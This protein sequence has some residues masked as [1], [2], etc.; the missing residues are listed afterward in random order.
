MDYLDLSPPAS[1]LIESIR[2]IGYSFEAAVADI[3]DN[4]ISAKAKNIAIQVSLN[5]KKQVVTSILDDGKGMTPNELKIAMSLG[6]KGPNTERDKSDLG[7]FG[8]GL[9]TASFSQAKLLRV[10]SK[11]NEDLSLYG[12]EWDLDHVI[13]TN[14]WQAREISSIEAEKKLNQINLEKFKNGTVVVWENCDRLIQG[15]ENYD[16]LSHHVNR[17]IF[18][19]NQ[20]LSLIFHKYLT[21][22]KLT[23]KINENAVLPMD[24]FCLLGKEDVAHSQELFQESLRIE[25]SKIKINGYLLPHINRMGGGARE[26]QISFEGDHTA[27]QGLYLYRLD[28]LIAYGGWQGIVR[29]SEANKL[30]RVE[31]SFDNEADNLWQ[32]DI[33]KATAILPVQIRSRIRDLVR[34]ASTKSKEV[35][36]SKTRMKKTNPNSIWE[37]VYDKEKKLI[38][39]QID[40]KHPIIQNF[41]EV[42]DSKEYLIDEFLFFI[43]NT[44]PADLISNDVVSNENKFHH[45]TDQIESKVEHLA[46]I[47]SSSGLEFKVFEQTILNCGLFGANL[48]DLKILVNKYKD[49][50]K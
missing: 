20:K 22:K 38:S 33:K 40:R 47:V 43:E 31:V 28:R 17:L 26:N 32:L 45:P 34:G 42:F 27:A 29:K 39:Y 7:R 30:A 18:Q 37:R 8:L 48:N 44:F 4:S 19:L 13:K 36:S 21:K 6:A 16:D 5:Q 35:F 25:S 12:I 49:K 41:I 1:S 24:P 50:F 9:K 10:I 2:S 46:D 15:I 23:I 3:I 14:K 11:K